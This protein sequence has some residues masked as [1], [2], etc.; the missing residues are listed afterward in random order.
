MHYVGRIASPAARRTKPRRLS[1][2]AFAEGANATD[3]RPESP[4]P[5]PDELS[6][7]FTEA[8]WRSLPWTRT[9]WLGRQISSAPSDLLAYQELIAEVRPDWVIET[10]TGDG[11]RSLFLASICELVG[12]GQVLSIDP[13]P[14]DDRPQHPR[15]RY[16]TAVA[17]EP[18]TAAAVREMAG[19]GAR[20][21]VV[22][23]SC[24]DRPK[25]TLEFEAFA[26]FVPVGVV[27]DTIVNGHPVWPAF[28]AGPAEAVK[29]ILTRHGEFAV[30]PLMEKYSL[31]FNPAGFLRR[32]R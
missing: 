28:G 11:G 8:V 27:A 9:S 25:T 14:V 29:Q 5:V 2:E 16:L 23:G 32:V 19:D 4:T 21:V 15:L 18:A 3:G 6:W 30:D 10:G 17:H 31:T 12:H 1:A 26:P 20:A 13:D 22:L 7:T 24:T